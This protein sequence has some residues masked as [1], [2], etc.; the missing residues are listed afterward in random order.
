MAFGGP[1]G[2]AVGI[3][4][5]L[6]ELGIKFKIFSEMGDWLKGMLD[7]AAGLTGSEFGIEDFTALN[8]VPFVLKVH[9]K[10]EEKEFVKNKIETLKYPI[11][12]LRDEE[13]M[14]CENGICKFIGD[15]EEVIV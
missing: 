13:G 7:W 9:Y 10:E 14:F 3:G 11:H 5:L 12:I 4:T 15:G 6:L 8:Y 1:V 2:I